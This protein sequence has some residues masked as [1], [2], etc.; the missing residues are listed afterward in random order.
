MKIV[1]CIK[2]SILPEYSYFGDIKNDQLLENGLKYGMNEFDHYA[3]QLAVSLKETHDCEVAVVSLG[4]TRVK[5]VLYEAIALGANS[6]VHVDANWSLPTDPF[7][8]ATA[9]HRVIRNLRADLIFTGAQSVDDNTSITPTVLAALLDTVSVWNVCRLESLDDKKAVVHREKEHGMV[10]VVEILLPAVLAIQTG[11]VP[12][13]YAPFVKLRNAKKQGLIYIPIDSL[14]LDIESYRQG[15]YIRLYE[16][17]PTGACKVVPGD[18]PTKAKSF[19]NILR[20][21]V[22]LRI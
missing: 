3:L 16:T 2:H 9:L 11:I 12:L 4:P 8:V 7:M 18:L 17:E 20:E 21:E 10:E 19:L 13:K 5:E 22:K 15:E 14:G 1:V 6:A